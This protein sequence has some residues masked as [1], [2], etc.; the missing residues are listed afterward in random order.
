MQKIRVFETFAGIG[1]QHKALEILKINK[2]IDY[3]IVAIS[4]WDIWS[5]ISYNAI[6]YDNKNIANG[7]TD[8]VM[9]DL[10]DKFTLSNDGKTPYDKDC[11]KRLPRSTRE[12]LYSSILNTN[13]LGSITEISGSSLIKKSGDIDLITY[14]FPCQDLSTAGSFHG[15]GKGMARGS[16]TRSGLLWEIERILIDLKNEQKLPKYLFLENVKAMLSQKNKGDFIEWLSFLQS[17][18]YNTQTYIMDSSKYGSAQSRQRVYALSVLDGGDEFIDTFKNSGQ[19]VELNIPKDVSK[20][21]NIKKNMT[22]VL[23][24]NY[25]NDVNS[26]SY[27]YTNE[28]IEATPNR[29]PSRKRMFENNYLLFSKESVEID[30]RS[31]SNHINYTKKN[32]GFYLPR[33]RTI[34]TKQDRHPN[35]GVVD[36]RGTILQNQQNKAKYRFLTTRETIV[37]MGFENC[38]YEKMVS[39]KEVKK[40]KLYKQ[41]GNSIVVNVLVSL[42][43]HLINIGEK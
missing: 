7:L 32:D 37:L 8:D 34:T 17:I 21:F 12:L 2:K 38:D 22:E 43:H 6:H 30:K 4:E 41:A 20:E 25:V 26:E 9:N 14:S 18:G 13:N 28:A 3:E 35:A 29:T 36:L 39:N 23:N 5:N 16:G 27:K 10:F 31:K 15:Y 11:V 33:C 40:E 19:I 24:L 42:I 1:A